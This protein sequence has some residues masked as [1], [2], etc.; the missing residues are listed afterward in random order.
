MN[1]GL[2]YLMGHVERNQGGVTSIVT[3]PRGVRI[4]LLGCLPVLVVAEW[5][6][7]VDALPE[8]TR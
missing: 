2:V 4:A 8:A 6:A 7:W 1:A 5:L 3:T